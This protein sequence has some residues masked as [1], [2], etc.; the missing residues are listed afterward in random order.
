MKTLNDIFSLI[1]EQTELNKNKMLKYVYR[2]DTRHNSITAQSVIFDEDKGEERIFEEIISS[3]SIA[4]PEAIQE[5]YW[6]IY[7]NRRTEK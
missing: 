4:T 3:N 6:R 5:V 1:A 2:I 7:N